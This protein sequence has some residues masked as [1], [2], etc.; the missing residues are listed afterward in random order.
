[1]MHSG[2]VTGSMAFI[3][4]SL[5]AYMSDPKSQ[6]SVLYRLGATIYLTDGACLLCNKDSDKY[7]NH[8]IE[9]TW[10]EDCQ[11]KLAEGCR[12]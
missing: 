1:M 12:R 11:A 8:I 3:H 2:L 9:V 5:A 10:E 4:M 6:Y 7:R